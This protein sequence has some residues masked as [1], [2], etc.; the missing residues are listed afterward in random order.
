MITTKVSTETSNVS[1]LPP[2]T[3]PSA[4]LTDLSHK[5]EEERAKTNFDHP[6]SLD[7]DLMI[8]HIRSL[9]NGRPIKVPTYCFKTHSR[10]EEIKTEAPKQ[11]V[12]VEGILILTHPVLREELD[13][14]VFVDADSDVRLTRRMARD[15]AERG[16]TV[17]E[18]IEQ[19]HATVR[20]MHEEWVEPSKK[21]ADLIVQT[22]NHSLDIAVK[23]LS[24]HLR[25]EAGIQKESP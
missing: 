10:K 5:P 12:I 20:P 15:I 4:F 7:T 3:S 19:Y 9:K 8:A 17:S 14:M 16:R 25:A 22:N 11:I 24:N 6:E 23:T 1:T 21:H 2:P 13:I 18:V